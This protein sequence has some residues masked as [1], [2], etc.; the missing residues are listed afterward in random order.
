MCAPN[1]NNSFSISSI[2][3][4]SAFHTVGKQIIVTKS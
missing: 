2:A 1:F 3:A 4:A